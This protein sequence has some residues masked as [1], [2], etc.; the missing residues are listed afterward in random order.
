[1][2]SENSKSEKGAEMGRKAEMKNDIAK[3]TSHLSGKSPAKILA[4]TRCY[5]FVKL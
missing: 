3:K 2:P 5:F 1:L 4:P